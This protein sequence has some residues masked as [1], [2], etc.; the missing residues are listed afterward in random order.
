MAL[1]SSI[2]A[3]SMTEP[4]MPGYTKRTTGSTDILPQTQDIYKSDNCEIKRLYCVN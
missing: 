4:V 2:G 3:K 1:N